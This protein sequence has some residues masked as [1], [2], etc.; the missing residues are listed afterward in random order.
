MPIPTLS[1]CMI[2]K[3]EEKN[4][5]RCL[6]SV[7]GLV[8]EIV[9]VDTGSTDDT[10]EIANQFKVNLYQTAWSGDFAFARNT[11]L[12]YA[13][14]QWILVLDADEELDAAAQSQLKEIL[15]NTQ[16]AGLRLCQ[17]NLLSPDDLVR[18][19]DIRIIRVF[20]N[21]PKIRFEGMI[22][23]SVLDSIARM[24]GL[25][26]N[27]DLIINHSGY[28]H[29]SVQG[30]SSRGERNLDLLINMLAGDPEDA[31]IHYQL[32]ITYKQL[33]MPQEARYH[34]TKLFGLD[35]SRLTPAIMGQGLMK[36]AQLDLAENN[37]EDCILNAQA[38]LEY[39]PDNQISMYLL[40]LAYMATGQVD[41]AYP[42]FVRIRQ[43]PSDNLKDIEKLDA[44]IVYCRQVLGLQT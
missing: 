25:I 18:H 12:D 16:A 31:Y 33:L 10:L 3:N 19:Q 15:S 36:L 38:S 23:E 7:Q 28:T 22:H 6:K 42:Y 37:E 39:D 21:N 34:L 35:T 20:R 32:G 13:S 8:D 2:V 4:L 17:R 27:T 11:S 9:I 30:N 43:S 24:G 14:G 40:A 44:V 5:T 29:S 1:L 41:Q 26:Q